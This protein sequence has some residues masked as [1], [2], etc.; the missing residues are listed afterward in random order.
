[1]S[2]LGD[3]LPV[4]LNDAEVSSAPASYTI[5]TGGARDRQQVYIMLTI[6]LI[7]LFAV[8]AFYLATHILISILAATFVTVPFI[9]LYILIVGAEARWTFD[10]SG[11]DYRAHS[12]FGLRRASVA[13]DDIAGVF[14]ETKKFS[15]IESFKLGFRLKNGQKMMLA[16]KYK[17]HQMKTMLHNL[18]PRLPDLPMPNLI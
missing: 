5:T 6:S 4:L 13:R 1:M 2:A 7:G 14:V 15:N 11:F 12:L 16:G 18:E 17:R 8:I 9:G 10:D 3:K